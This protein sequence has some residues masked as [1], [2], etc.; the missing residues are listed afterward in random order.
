M[1]DRFSEPVVVFRCEKAAN[2]FVKP[3]LKKYEYCKKVMKKRFNKNLI[4]SG[5]K[6]IYF[7]KIC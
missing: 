5:K 2:D 7:S 3:I 4:I 1:D 6:N